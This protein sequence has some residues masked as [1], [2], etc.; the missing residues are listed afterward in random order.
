MGFDKPTL[1]PKE[2]R[3]KKT[4]ATKKR[5]IQETTADDEGGNEPPAKAQRV[6][7]D[8]SGVRRSSR[9]AGKTV[10]YRNEVVKGSPVPI[11]FS[12][13]V[14]TSDNLGPLGRETGHRKYDPLAFLFHQ[15]FHY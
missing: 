12:S 7:S 5:N 13:G 14:K 10:D 2:T 11:S 6:E 9:N 4:P 8:P 1:E 3:V 15:Y